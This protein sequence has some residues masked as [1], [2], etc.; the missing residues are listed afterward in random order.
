MPLIAG[1]F[2]NSTDL[3]SRVK[4]NPFKV[5]RSFLLL[6][7][8]L[9]TSVT[10]IVSPISN[11]HFFPGTAAMPFSGRFRMHALTDCFLS[12]FSPAKQNFIRAPQQ[13]QSSDRRL[14]DIMR[15]MGTETLCQYIL[16]A[17]R[18]Q[19]RTNRSAGN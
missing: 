18:L 1:V 4:P 12:D 15:V 13:T 8:P 10:L 14:Y 3:L 16:Y 11:S 9:L 6:P 17:G 7:M 19:N 2:F 5:S